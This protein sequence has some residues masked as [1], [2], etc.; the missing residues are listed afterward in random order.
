[1]PAPVKFYE[2]LT[3]RLCKETDRKKQDELLDLWWAAENL[4]T[5]W[6][7]KEWGFDPEKWEFE[8]RDLIAKNDQKASLQSKVNNNKSE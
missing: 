4:A 5:E 2:Q 3:Q 8:K 7:A 1:M 6:D